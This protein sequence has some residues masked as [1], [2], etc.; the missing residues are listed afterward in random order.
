MMSKMIVLTAPS[1]GGKT[2]IKKHLL[3]EYNEL[4]FSISVTTREKRPSEID[5]KDYYF[6][7]TK[8]FNQLIEE[9]AFLEWEEVYKNQFYGTL[10]S[11]VD[12]LWA[13]GKHIV[14]DVDVHGAQDIKKMY[15]DRCM[16]VFIRPPSIQVIVDR[17]KGRETETAESLAKRVRRIER[18]MSF[19][20]KFDKVLINDLLLV[21]FKEAENLV[22]SFLDIH[23][24]EEE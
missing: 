1:G 2:T 24:S 5:G 12:R 13:L 22:E 15:G 3:E 10:K 4:G 17:L 11:E 23:S 6:R 8:E 20:H 16:A 18:E 19:E 9:D 21:A 7:S 14:F